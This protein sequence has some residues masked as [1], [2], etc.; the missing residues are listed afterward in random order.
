VPRRG[1]SGRRQR[2][3]R[4]GA[5]HLR[6]DISGV[7]RRQIDAAQAAAGLQA[8]TGQGVFAAVV[9]RHAP[10]PGHGTFLAPS[11]ITARRRCGRAARVGATTMPLYEYECD[12][13][14][15]RFELIRRFSDP[16]ADT[17]AV[18][19]AGPV[20][21]LFSS[22]AIQFK[23]SGFYITDYP[24]K[25]QKAAAKG[26]QGEKAERA[27][28]AEKGEKADKGEKA[29]RAEKGERGEKGDKAE[30]AGSGTANAKDR[31]NAK[32]QAAKGKEAKGDKSSGGSS[33][34]KA[35]PASS[36]SSGS[37]KAKSRSE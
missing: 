9:S 18:C 7:Q 12:A 27:E 16:P 35:A 19:G 17:C 4:S 10:R 29:E 21:K 25:D 3:A 5:R 11:S 6:P 33:G 13:C 2:A 23:G 14:G 34:D 37:N 36:T 28:K 31:A 30:G 1:L 32:G 20:R 24:K 26:E 15:R 8:T 22:P